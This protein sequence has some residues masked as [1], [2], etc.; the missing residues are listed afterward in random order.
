MIN[1]SKISF[2]YIFIGIFI[3]GFLLIL[4]TIFSHYF[5]HFISDTLPLPRILY[6]YVFAYSPFLGYF[7]WLLAIKLKNNNLLLFASGI[8]LFS[9][10]TYFLFGILQIIYLPSIPLGIIPIFVSIIYAISG[11]KLFIAIEKKHIFIGFVGPALILLFSQIYN[12]PWKLITHLP[13]VS[14]VNLKNTNMNKTYLHSLTFRN[15]VLNGSSFKNSYFD[16]VSFSG[17]SLQ[18]V[19]FNNS[20]LYM[21]TFESCDLKNAELNFNALGRVIIRNSNLCGANLV[22]LR[23]PSYVKEPSGVYTWDGTIYDSKTIFPPGFNPVKSEM[24]YKD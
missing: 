14:N 17:S 16:M 18:N 10:V 3:P 8:I 20:K 19:N 24:V 23:E 11:L 7:C 22:K 5:I 6:L 4:D 13:K 21:V 15:V 9:S 1:K 2:F 12:Q